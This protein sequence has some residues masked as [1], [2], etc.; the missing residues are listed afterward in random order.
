MKIDNQILK[1]VTECKYLV[2]AL[3]DNLTCTKDIERAK[4]SF[5]KQF[6]SLNNKF[7]CM[8]QKV[9]ISLIKLHAMSFYGVETW[10]IKLHT[11][12]LNNTPIAYDKAIKRTCNRRAYDSNHDCLERVNL[13]IF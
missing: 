4:K 2:V 7:Y 11:K 12:G 10:F 13:T 8:D 9:L 1:S 6:F 5:F 3:S